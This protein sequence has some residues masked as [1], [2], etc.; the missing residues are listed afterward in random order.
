[1]SWGL[2]L[3]GGMANGLA[4]IGVVETLERE[5]LKPDCIAGSSMGAIVAALWALG[6]PADSFRELLSGVTL[7]NAAVVSESVFH[8]GPHGG[9]LRQN[10][11]GL[12]ASVLDG[13]RIGDCAIP[14]V[15]VAGRVKAPVDW[16]Q[17]LRSGS[18]DALYDHVELHVFQEDTLLIDALLATSAVPVL[19]SP[20]RIGDD[21][22]VDLV[23]F[24]AVPARTLR[25][26][27]APDRVIATDTTPA[28]DAI[29]AYL[30][31]L[32][33]SMIAEGRDSLKQS[34]DACD[35]VIRPEMPANLIRFDKGPAFA[36]A[37][38]AA[39][40]SALPEIRALIG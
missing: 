24:G 36:D 26:T 15:C 40:R 10:L 35:L 22:F 38:A 3:S 6:V 32:F 5:G 2:V 4:N 11:K 9:V 29:A 12:L 25:K 8:G 17:L 39:T 23:N 7:W 16:L 1:M 28:Y 31:H 27:C 37:G 14:F 33:V 34:L 30:P 13:K 21:E 19:F 20:V 18:A